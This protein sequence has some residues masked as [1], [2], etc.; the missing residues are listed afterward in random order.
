MT[1]PL[2][3]TSRPS[4]ARSPAPDGSPADLPAADQ[5]PPDASTPDQTPPDQ[6]TPQP[7]ASGPAGASGKSPPAE[8]KFPCRK[9]GARLT[10]DPSAAALQCPYCGYVERIEPQAA[11]IEEHDLDEYL[12]RQASEETVLAGR[13]SQVRCGSCGAVVLLEDHVATDRCPYCAAVL[14]NQPEAAQAMIPPESLLP[15]RIAQREAVQAF[16]RWVG[17]LWFAPSELL[18]L[19]TLGQLSGVYAPF[20]TYDSMTYT[21]YTGARGVD[22]TTTETFTTT[23]AQGQ[24]E[25]VSRPVTRTDWY[26][27]SGQVDHFFDDVLI[28]ASGSLPPATV[29]E[30]TPWDLGRLEPFDPAFLAGFKT[31]RYTIGLCDGFRAARQRMDG[32][33]RRLCCEDIG[34]NHQQLNS[35]RTQHVGVTFK[36]LLLPIWVAAYSYRNRPYRILVNARTGE[37]IGTRP[38]SW[39]KISTLVAALALVAAAIALAIAAGH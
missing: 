27:V 33:I 13:S 12:R 15:F 30:L 28:Y 2:Q 21:H 23:N 5:T 35:V 7:A 20:W 34:G 18:K 32:V 14:Q 22:F 9:C 25:T 37:V 31:E 17:G 4:A 8:R 10:F 19:A 1:T 6:S 39:T 3:P 11:Q 24:V 38:Y 26:P 29:A 36:H 16:S